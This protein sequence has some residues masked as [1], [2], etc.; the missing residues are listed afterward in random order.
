MDFLDIINVFFWNCRYLNSFP[1]VFLHIRFLNGVRCIWKCNVCRRKN[2]DVSHYFYCSNVIFMNSSTKGFLFNTDNLVLRMNIRHRYRWH[3]GQSK[4][5]VSCLSYLLLFKLS[6][7]S[8]LLDEMF[9][10]SF[11]SL[12]PSGTRSPTFISAFRLKWRTRETLCHKN[13]PCVYT[14]DTKTFW[15]LPFTTTFR[16]R[17]W[18]VFL[19]LSWGLFENTFSTFT[20]N[21]MTS[22]GTVTF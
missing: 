17:T 9:W 15:T 8:S 10:L 14:D 16:K 18:F 5:S 13:S 22:S 2:M 11:I 6:T 21:I 3:S 1:F 20:W 7:A 12:S 19:T 4:E